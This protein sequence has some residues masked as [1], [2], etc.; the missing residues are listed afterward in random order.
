MSTNSMG[1]TIAVPSQ[2]SGPIYAVQVSGDLTIIA[3][4]NHTDGSGVQIPTAGIDIDADL[5]MAT[6]YNLTNTRSVR[7]VSQGSALALAGDL[8]SIYVVNGDLYYNNGT[9]VHVQITSGAALNA[10][11]LNGFTGLAGTTGAATYNNGTGTFTFTS[12]TG[13]KATMAGGPVLIADVAANAFSITIKSPTSL[14]SAYSLIL[15]AALP[16]S[17]LPLTVTSGGVLAAAQ[18]VAAQIANNTITSAQ[19][20]APSLTTMTP[21]INGWVSGSVSHP[22]KYWKGI[23]GVVHMQGQVNAS[24]ASADSSFFSV[25]AGFRPLVDIELAVSANGLLGILLVGSSGSLSLVNTSAA[26]TSGFLDG[27][28]YLGE[29]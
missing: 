12:S 18:I 23:D 3:E 9:G 21:L 10:S 16:G 2:T 29:A 27:A 24:G 6:L 7:M 13:V 1:L 20:V 19:L 26:V 11:A 14:G 28:N 4:H 15:P 8:D 25:P 5:S 22:P 17:T